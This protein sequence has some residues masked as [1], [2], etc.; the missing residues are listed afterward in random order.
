MFVS[1][2]KVTVTIPAETPRSGTYKISQEDGDN[3]TLVFSR[4]EGGRDEA[5]LRFV[6]EESLRWSLPEGPEIV[7]VRAKN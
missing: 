2:S 1:G 5:R 4:A 7:L 3:L 6:G